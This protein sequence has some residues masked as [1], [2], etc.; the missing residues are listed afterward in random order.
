M[1]N[2]I[3]VLALFAI[4]GAIIGW[5]YWSTCE[6]PE[7]EAGWI[8]QLLL[9]YGYSLPITYQQIGEHGKIIKRR[10]MRRFSYRMSYQSYL[11]MVA[12]YK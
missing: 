9:N 4:V 5:E 3:E 10:W 6:D 7:Q 8:Y 12:E 2:Y 11:K 1:H